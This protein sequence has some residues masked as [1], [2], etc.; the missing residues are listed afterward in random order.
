MTEC[1][2]SCVSIKS[3]KKDLK[4]DRK[5]EVYEGE[6]II[7]YP[8]FGAPLIMKPGQ[9]LRLFVLFER[10]LYNLYTSEFA[11]GHA[12]T[13]ETIYVINKSLKINPWN[14]GKKKP[15]KLLFSKAEALNNIRCHRIKTISVV[16]REVMDK[17][18]Q[19]IGLLRPATAANYIRHKLNFQFLFE[20]EI[21]HLVLNDKTLYDCAW[22]L[23]D[24]ASPANSMQP[25]LPFSERQ[26]L[27]AE[28]YIKNGT[29]FIKESEGYKITNDD[30][31]KFKFETTPSLPLQNRHPLYITSK[32]KLNLGQLTDIHVSSRQMPMQVCEAQVLPNAASD[33]SPMIGSMVNISFNTFKNL[34]DQMGK[35]DDIDLLVLT[36]DLIDF[37][38]N[39]DPASVGKGWEED[40]KKPATMWVW[41]DPKYY[42]DAKAYPF[43]IDML[44]IYSLLNYYVQTYQKPIVMLTGNHEAYENPYGISPRVGQFWGYKPTGMTKANEGI[45]SDHNLT[46]YEATL[47]YG[48]AYNYWK[49]IHNFEPKYLEWFYMMFNPLSDFSFS[50]GTQSFTALEWEDSE[51]ILTNT[52]GGNLPRAS[53]AISDS[54]LALL[55]ESSKRGKDRVLLTH[56][57][58][59]S[60]GYNHQITEEGEVNYND[61]V[62]LGIT[63]QSIMSHFEEGTFLTNR[64]TVYNM[65]YDGAFTHVFSGHSHR[66]GFYVM[67]DKMGLLS[68]VKVQG[69]LIHKDKMLHPTKLLK[70]GKARLIVGA[71]AGPIPGQNDYG[72]AK[73]KGL[74]SWSLDYPSGN[75]LKFDGSNDTLHLKTCSL[76]TAK[77]R[78]AVALSFFDDLNERVFQ[79]FESGKNESEFEI[80]LHS[81]LPAEQF[82]ET[83][84]L[85][86][87]QNKKW[88]PYAMNVLD[89][90]QR[91]LKTKIINSDGNFSFKEKLGDSKSRSKYTF[92]QIS[93]NKR[94]AHRTGYRQYNFDSLW[95]YPIRMINKKKEAEE[96]SM[97]ADSYSPY[98]NM[99]NQAMLQ[100]EIDNTFGYRVEPHGEVPDFQ[101]YRKTFANY[102]TGVSTPRS[103]VSDE[104]LP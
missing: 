72:D 24:P 20:L 68:N 97:L 5:E 99:H 26:D 22:A 10:K 8:S 101:W 4:F 2:E 44:T 94:L 95:I 76:P 57:T 7:L 75:V 15:K 51:Q 55:K 16:A 37:N 1:A 102:S 29:D 91:K 3:K 88:I 62:N 65:L 50:Y 96:M 27:I 42:N 36:G 46:I 11:Q 79:K 40:F 49:N 63:K 58:F 66:A 12:S 93:F 52:G 85:Y 17:D 30:T 104:S 56:F 41:M 54:Q 9:T 89:Q 53:K 82:I 47:L 98:N 69:H 67:T 86:T 38:Q 48:P 59:V 84:A 39:F 13:P 78:F 23:H 64:K 90:G 60:Y 21:D 80:T 31:F 103:R 34:L 100:R 32:P 25:P 18:N 71:S 43:Y 87:Y 19:L 28:N 61:A 6:A 92:L 83:I 81:D 14:N 77:P 74:T 35:D 73:E 70:G 33:K 45:P